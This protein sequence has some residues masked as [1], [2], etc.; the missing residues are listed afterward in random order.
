MMGRFTKVIFYFISGYWQSLNDE[1][2]LNAKCFK[3]LTCDPKDDVVD[4]FSSLP[5]GVACKISK[6]DYSDEKWKAFYQALCLIFDIE[7]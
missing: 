1:N 5:V 2:F 7:D 4:N 3:I 6:T